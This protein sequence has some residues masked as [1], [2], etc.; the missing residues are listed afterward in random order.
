MLK[1]RIRT[2][3]Y[4]DSMIQNPQL[5]KGKV[6]LDVGCGTGILS[7]FAANAGAQ[8]VYALDCSAIVEHAKEIIEENGFQSRITVIRG[9]VEDI[10]LPVE[11]VD[12]IISEWMGYCLLYENMLETVIFARD[13]WLAPGGLMFPDKA[14]MF[15]VGIEDSQYRMS[16]IDWWDN[17]YGFKMSCLKREALIEPLVDICEPQQVMTNEVLLKSFDLQTVKKEDLSFVAPFSLIAHQRDACHAVVVYFNVEFTHGR[18]RIVL[19]TGPKN[20]ET[21]WKQTVFY[22]PEPIHMN[23]RDRIEGLFRIHS[24]AK[25]PRDMDIDIAYVHTSTPSDFVYKPAN[26]AGAAGAAA[27]SSTTGSSSSSTSSSSSSSASES[28]PPYVP[29]LPLVQPTQQVIS[30]QEM[31]YKLR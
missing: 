31:C 24:N 3:S 7:M 29:L 4:R 2:L 22:I 19:P 11:K 16:K 9:K 25:N 6:V 5:F 26:S 8:H 28:K 20:P 21:H 17:V 18:Q 23:F 12:I 1:D 15:M 10:T 27:A 14:N 30:S 13:K